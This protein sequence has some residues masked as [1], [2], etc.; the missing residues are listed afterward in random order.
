VGL[1]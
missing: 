1:T